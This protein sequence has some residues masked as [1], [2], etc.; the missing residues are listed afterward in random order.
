MFAF[1]SRLQPPRHVT[2]RFFIAREGNFAVIF[3]V[4]APVLMIAAGSAV[5]YSRA[6]SV[7]QRMQA[8]ADAGAL[9]AATA[10]RNGMSV[11][12]AQSFA[13]A[14]Y[15]NN[16]NG[17]VSASS[18]AKVA[19]AGA[20]VTATVGGS[21]DVT[22]TLAHFLGVSSI[23][24]S[25]SATAGATV[26]GTQTVAGGQL[27]SYG[28]VTAD[29][30]YTVGNAARVEFPCVAGAW[31]NLLSDGGIEINGYC[32][33]N[34]AAKDLD[35]LS[36]YGAYYEIEVV[37][38]PH[39]I[40]FN[41]LTPAGAPASALG[42]YAQ[43]TVDG[44]SYGSTSSANILTDSQNNIQASLNGNPTSPYSGYVTI[45]SDT[46][47]IVTTSNY[48][49]IVG[50]LVLAPPNAN[51]I[52]AGGVLSVTATNAGMCG[53][54]GGLLGAMLAAGAAQVLDNAPYIV[55][56]G[57]TTTQPFNWTPKCGSAGSVN[58]ARLT[59]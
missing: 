49:I 7:K 9:A 20:N 44:V 5:D 29:P 51:P 2:E 1:L 46:S 54:P 56:S 50:G 6:V 45:N 4:A 43:V 53:S 31:T 8:A 34:A 36:T 16:L 30:Y 38:G 41:T 15:A 3:A 33:T 27:N 17:I 11:G 24:V 22:T 28:V 39:K 19:V 55:P 14:V 52:G 47:M 21:A 18:T 13:A 10:A 58:V 12:D 59:Q 35:Q 32:A 40:I 37:A 48:N 23:S 25:A 26:G 42:L 57:S